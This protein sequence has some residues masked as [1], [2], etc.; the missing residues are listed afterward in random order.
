MEFKRFFNFLKIFLLLILFA[1]IRIRIVFAWIRISNEFF[2]I[3]DLDPS[4]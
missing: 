2:P 1:W 4:K 3:L